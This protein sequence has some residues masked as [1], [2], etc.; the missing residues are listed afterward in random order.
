LEGAGLLEAALEAAAE[1]VGNF[2]LLIFE[3]RVFPKNGKM[4]LKKSLD[5]SF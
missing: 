2:S 4:L 5:K 3:G 1:V